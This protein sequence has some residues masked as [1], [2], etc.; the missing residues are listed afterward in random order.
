MSLSCSEARS[1]TEEGLVGKGQSHHSQQDNIR[2]FVALLSPEQAPLPY[3]SCACHL[4]RPRSFLGFRE[5]AVSFW[6]LDT[7]RSGNFH[8]G[9]PGKSPHVWFLGFPGLAFSSRHLCKESQGTPWLPHNHPKAQ[10]GV[11]WRESHTV[12]HTL[13]L[14]GIWL[15]MSL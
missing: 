6:K 15:I 12:A 4:Y 1:R 2:R 14:T 8:H 11:F 10:A 7:L 3:G 5:E 9:S 13:M